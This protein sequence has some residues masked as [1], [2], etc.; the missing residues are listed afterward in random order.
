MPNASEARLNILLLCCEFPP[1]GGGAAKVTAGLSRELVR[2]GHRVDLVTMACRGLTL[3]EQVDGVSVYRSRCLRFHT[4]RS[5][6]IELLSYVFAALPLTRRLIRRGHYDVCNA[7]FLFPDALLARLAFQSKAMPLVVTA[8]GSDIPG[9]NPDRFRLLHKVAKPFWRKLARGVDSIVCPSPTLMRLTLAAEPS[10]RTVSI[11]NGFDLNHF[12]PATVRSRRILVVSRFFKRKGIQHL[13]KAYLTSDL[14]YELHIVG[15]GPY[16]SALESL[17]QKESKPVRFWGWLDHNSPQLKSLYATAEIFALPS[18]AENF[19][20]SLLEAMASELAIIT[21]SGTGCADVVGECAV[22]V[23]PNDVEALK[24]ALA[25][26]ASNADLR[27]RLAK[28]GR[29]RFKTLF[30]WP[31]VAQSYV[32]L[33]LS[34]RGRGSLQTSTEIA[35]N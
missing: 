23:P 1:L 5:N 8:H 17:V 20:V 34:L 2:L 32:D 15:D 27:R 22:L 33:F 9:Y 25:R 26:L 12:R 18:E 29:E 3:R 4:H 21:T 35:A 16:R 24:S 13:I 10:A 28:A 14:V 30:T 19:P 7:H 11:P 31:T 6:P